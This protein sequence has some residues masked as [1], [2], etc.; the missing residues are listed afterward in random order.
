V[1]TIAS[2]P[3][4]LLARVFERLPVDTRLRAAEVRRGWRSVLAAE[5]GLWTAL[6]MS[7]SSGVEHEVTDALL[8]A[9]AARAGGAL[10]TLDLTG[11]YDVSDDALLEVV[12]ANAGSLLELRVSGD[13]QVEALLR[14]AP[15]LLQLVTDVEWADVGAATRML[16]GEGVFQPLRVRTLN[17]NGDGADDAALRALA[18]ALAAHASP[19]TSFQLSNCVQPDAADVPVALLDAA[20]ANH[21][22]ALELTACTL[23]PASAPSLARLLGGAALTSLYIVDHEHVQLL[24][25]PAAALLGGA[26]RKNGVL[27]HL[28]LCRV[29]LWDDLAAAVTLLSSLSAHPSLRELTLAHNIVAPAHAACSGAALFALVASNAP[30]LQTLNV[31]AWRLGDAGLRPLFEALPHNTHLRMLGCSRNDMSEACARDVLVPAVRANASLMALW[32]EQQWEG[33]Q[34]AKDF[35]ARRT[36]AAT[37]R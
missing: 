5:R 30:A 31:H 28:A 19:L 35:V 6:D 11:C 27:Q 33:V 17:V 29:R 7:E 22:A 23:I 34:E 12:T 15:R 1:A 13:V 9:A 10:A 4:A 24:D 26:L 37:R 8:R 3:D 21:T 25:A 18:A 2:L 14:A 20:L 32:V 16:R 36:A